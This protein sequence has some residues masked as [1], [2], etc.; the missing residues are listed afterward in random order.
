[1]LLIVRSYVPTVRTVLNN[2]AIFILCG[3]CTPLCIVLFFAA[4]KPTVLPLPPG[5]NEMNEYGC[6][7]QG[8]VFSQSKVQDMIK[9]YEEKNVGFV[10]MLTEE[11]GDRYG[12]VRW[13]LTPSVLQHVGKRSSKGD[14]YGGN[15][16]YNRSV[17]EKIWNFAF[18]MNDASVLRKAHD[19]V[20][21]R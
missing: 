2:T 8:L 16:K 1:M 12:D 18:E 21:K 9:W 3:A 15:S 17:A 6:C 11:Y 14:D 19:K 4:G 5:V 20:Y 13:A 10:D 7:S